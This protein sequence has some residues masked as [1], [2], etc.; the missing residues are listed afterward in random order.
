MRAVTCARSMLVFALLL[1]VLA[2]SGCAKDVGDGPPGPEACGAG[3]APRCSGGRI[4]AAEQCVPCQVGA[5]C[6]VEYGAGAT[7]TEGVCQPADEPPCPE[8]SAGCPCY[9]NGTC[10]EGVCAGGVCPE[11]DPC[12]E[13]STGCP[14][15]ANGTCDEGA[16]VD[17]VCVADEPCPDGEAGCPCRPEGGAEPPCDG[18]LRC[19]AEQL[20]EACP[21]GE[22]GCACAEGALCAPGLRCGE[23]EVCEPCP[24][25][26]LDC[27]CG[28]GDV[29]GEGLRCTPGGTCEGCP[30]G[31]LGCACPAEGGCDEGLR[32][33]GEGLCV[34]C[35]AGELGCVC[36]AE[37]GCGEGLR[38]GPDDLCVEC[39]AGDLGCACGLEQ[40]CA[41]G[42]CREGTCT[43][44]SLGWLGCGCLAEGGC[45]EGQCVG[46]ECVDCERG[47]LACTCFDNGTCAEGLRC[48]E[49]G[50][51]ELCPPGEGG[52]VCRG[53]APE[54]DDPLLCQ[55]QVCAPD[56]CP[57][58][59]DGCPCLDGDAC[60]E[61][62]SCMEGGL[63]AA[64]TTDIVGCPCSDEGECG[65]DLVC[66]GDDETC[67]DALLCEQAACLEHQLCEQE[68]GVDAV[69]LLDCEPGW[70]WSEANGACEAVVLANCS[71]GAEGSILDECQAA[72]RACVEQAGGAQCGDCEQG[73]TDEAGALQQCRVIVNCG[74]GQEGSILA[75]CV[76]ANRGCL[77]AADGARCGDCANGYTDEGGTLQ[78]CRAVQDCAAVG[79]AAEHRTCTLPADHADASCGG[80][81]PGYRAEGDECVLPNCTAGALG[82]IVEQCALEHRDCAPPAPDAPDGTPAICGR[83][84]ASFAENDDGDCQAVVSCLDAGCAALNRTCVGQDPFRLCGRCL[85][86]TFAADPD[87]DLSPCRAPLT[88]DDIVCLE[89]EVC[90]SGGPAEDATC[91][92]TGCLDGEAFSL[93]SGRCE[94]CFVDCDAA[95]EGETGRPWPYTLS[96]AIECICETEDGY[97]WDNGLER[98]AKPC[99]ADADGWVRADARPYVEHDDPSL[100]DNARC[101]VRQ[102]DRFALRNEFGQQLNVFLC[103]TDEE[104]LVP[105]SP[106]GRDPQVKTCLDP[107]R[108]ALYESKRND[109]QAELQQ[110]RFAPTYGPDGAGRPLL[111]REL[112]PVTRACVARDADYNDNG[113]S[114]LG[115]WQ[116]RTPDAQESVFFAGMVHYLELHRTWYEPLNDNNPGLGQLVIAER[117]RCEAGFPITYDGQADYWRSCN[118]NR[119]AEFD[120][121]DGDVGPDWNMDFAQYSCTPDQATGRINPGCPMPPPPT[122]E[123][124]LSWEIPLHGHCGVEL[125]LPA[126]AECDDPE[127]SEYPCILDPET[128]AATV[129]RGML[130]HSQFKCVSAGAEAVGL[131]TLPLE[132]FA[133]ERYAFSR[134]AA[135]CPEGDPECAADCTVDANGVLTGCAASSER[136]GG[137]ARSVLNPAWP[138]IECTPTAAPEAGDVGF[139]RVLYAASQP[140]GY[141]RGCIN[142][143]RPVLP[144]CDPNTDPGCSLS[145]EVAAWRALCPGWASSPAAV[146]GQH[147]QFDFGRLQCGCGNNYGGVGCTQGCVNEDVNLSP[148]LQ[149]VPRIGFWMCAGFAA[150][151][152]EPAAPAEGE[153]EGE[154]PVE[155]VLEGGGWRLRGEVPAGMIPTDGQPLCEGD[156][157]SDGFVVR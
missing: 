19:G 86:G 72:H 143:W 47:E 152:F 126:D 13:G 59:T 106:Q 4:C 154:Q 105:L 33:G 97:Y 156:D 94:Q 145:P 48:P 39:P 51:C 146:A 40:A 88:C 45:T 102:I 104:L 70:A 36:P 52:C 101:T 83:C 137:V 35:P 128:G 49:A 79:C 54:C 1:L 121:S 157:C 16:C 99:D 107:A 61:P 116:G 66:D 18:G 117:S 14:C 92:R 7:C 20:C 46:G 67:R 149:L 139:A 108:A 151:G 44:C 73:Y 113:A 55:E 68:A 122:D 69:C 127:Q 95:R 93:W 133:P 23:A 87:D 57:A 110:S 76:A 77:E 25:G 84:V 131:P 65:D 24:S 96:G 38:C 78:Q 144:D 43:E 118:R 141:V 26:E 98:G 111:A 147:D 56:P 91:L 5:Q 28:E 15:Y 85:D 89:D 114:D 81:L 132:V 150:T 22:R 9:A 60:D 71:L 17:A 142:E 31:E 12:P 82:S 138:R 27:V 37:G 41:E 50:L 11:E 32:C 21:V 90:S 140:E 62:L 136:P 125:P 6:E 74:D 123:L 64:C 134:C 10:D 120:P 153:G 63:C 103:H 8:G 112:N 148:D 119:D 30:A 100:A 53:E 42:V 109:D 75:D 3:A 34:E 2:G 135:A 80:C 58:G 115:E 29:C 124:P 129:W 130:H 155:A